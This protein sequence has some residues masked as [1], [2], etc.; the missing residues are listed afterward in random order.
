MRTLET[1]FFEVSYSSFQ[2]RVIT[3]GS[4]IIASCCTLDN[5]D[6]RDFETD[7]WSSVE[8][9]DRPTGKFC[10]ILCETGSKIWGFHLWNW[11]QRARMSDGQ[12]A[13]C[14]DCGLSYISRHLRAGCSTLAAGLDRDRSDH[15]YLASPHSG[16]KPAKSSWVLNGDDDYC[17]PRN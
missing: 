10:C 8:T 11:R 1:F 12:D 13:L 14:H 15:L 7:V 3:A 2:L 5:E 9:D 4:F 6:E 17:L 16:R